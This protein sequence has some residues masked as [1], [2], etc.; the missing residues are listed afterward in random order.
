LL[1]TSELVEQVAMSESKFLRKMK[2]MSFG[3][4]VPPLIRR[5]PKKQVKLLKIIRLSLL[6]QQLQ[7]LNPMV[8]MAS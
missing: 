1:S 8:R 4:I 7:A 2:K 5:F 3:L 6:M